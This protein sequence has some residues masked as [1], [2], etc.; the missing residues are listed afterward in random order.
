MIKDKLSYHSLSEEL[1]SIEGYAPAHFQHFIS[2]LPFG[3]LDDQPW[4]QK[5]IIKRDNRRER[6]TKILLGWVREYFGL[7]FVFYPMPGWHVTPMDVFGEDHVV[8]L[9]NDDQHPYLQD[10]GRGARIMADVFSSPLPDAVFEGAFLRL[11]EKRDIGK[12]NI[13]KLVSVLRRVVKPEGIVIIDKWG[14]DQTVKYCR[15]QLQEASIPDQIRKI[16]RNDFVIFTNKDRV[17]K[18]FLHRFF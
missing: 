18:G 17:H 9:S 5:S 12:E 8:Y 1:P 13:P 7:K 15:K 11:K 16:I 6:N 10:I 14:A 4:L 2:N 3:G